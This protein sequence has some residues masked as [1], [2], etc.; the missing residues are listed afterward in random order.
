MESQVRARQKCLGTELH[1]M[2]EPDFKVT[3]HFRNFENEILMNIL[4]IGK[5]LVNNIKGNI[6]IN[7]RQ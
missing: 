7:I 4:V 6:N 1:E 2:R 3:Y 5:C